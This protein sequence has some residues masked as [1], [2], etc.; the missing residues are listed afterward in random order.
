MLFKYMGLRNTKWFNYLVL[1]MMIC[2]TKVIAEGEFD[3]KY[4]LYH[5]IINKFQN[6]SEHYPHLIKWESTHDLYNI[7]H[8]YGEWGNSQCTI[9]LARISDYNYNNPNK[10]QVYL[11]GSVHGDEQLGPNALTYLA[12]YLVTEHST[13]QYIQTL[14]R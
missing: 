12:E 8:Q 11:S 1:V 9:Y 3:Y 10:V 6:L 14:L 7:P 4:L 5:D 13:T 2:W